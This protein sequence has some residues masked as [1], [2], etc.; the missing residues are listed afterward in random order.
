MHRIGIR[1]EDKN[2]FERR[3]PLT[4]AHVETLGREHGVPCTVQPSPRRTFDDEAYRRAGAAVDEDLSG[5]DVVLGV[6]EIPLAQLLAEK[7]YL[8]FSHTIKGQPYNMPMLR[9]LL[10]LGCT[11]IDY[12]CIVDETGRRLVFFGQ[13][14]GLAGMIDT[15]WALGQRLDQEQGLKTA[16][17]TVQQAHA[18]PSLTDAKAAIS[19]VARRLRTEGI[20]R[21][22]RP[23]VFGFAGY[24]NVSIGAQEIVDLLE[25]QEISPERFGEIDADDDWPCYK[26]VF[27]EEHLVQRRSG[28]FELQHYYQE[29]DA[30]R[31]VFA[32]RYLDRLTV[33]VNCIFWDARYPRLVTLADLASLYGGPTP[34]RLQVIGDISCDVG[35]AIEA[36]VHTTD[37][38]NPVFLYDVHEQ[39]AVDGLTGAGPLILAVDNLPAE[40]PRDASE[41]FS[42]TL[43]PFIPAVAAADFGAPLERAGLPEPL[44]EAVIVQGGAL[45]PKFEYLSEHLSAEDED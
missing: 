14:A 19:A 40:L 15:L 36:T 32:E 10:Q 34:P 16:L 31:P 26:V 1:R 5:C 13:H 7:T 28:A 20:P 2:P 33:L 37:R 38:A 24:G 30:Y 23:L 17:A 45:T 44:R 25:P 43:L 22:L 42:D 9:R 4:P 21:A 27:R 3:T 35:G 11:L 6:K 29:P 41:W 8:F 12:E 18:Y 39:R